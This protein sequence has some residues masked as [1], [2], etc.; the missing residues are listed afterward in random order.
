M[1]EITKSATA[2]MSTLLPEPALR[3]SELLAGET[4]AVGDACYIKSDGLVWRATG[5]AANAAARVRGF[6]LEA[7][8]AGDPVTLVHDVVIR[9]G[10]GLTPGADL[11]LSGTVAGGLADAAST[12][13]T[14]PIAYAKDATR[15]RVLPLK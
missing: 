5:A 11:Y 6:A 3:E 12:G 15:I 7:A 4:I 13:G 1:A 14:S 8:A 9:Y 2:S 10:A